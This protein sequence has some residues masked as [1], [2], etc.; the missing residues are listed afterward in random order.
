MLQAESHVIGTHPSVPLVFETL[1]GLLATDRSRARRA[2]LAS[3]IA[4][5]PFRQEVI[6]ATGTF[7]LHTPR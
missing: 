5:L 1:P 2:V 3:E 7:Q 4:L 6:A